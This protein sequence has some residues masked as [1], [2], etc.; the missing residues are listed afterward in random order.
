MPRPCVHKLPPSLQRIRSPVGLFGLVADDMRKGVLG[1]LAR[2][3]RLVAGPIAEGAA[4]AVNRRILNP[5]ATKQ[6]FQRHRRKR[7]VGALAGENEVGDLRLV[8]P[9]Q[10]RERGLAERNSM[11]ARSLRAL[12]RDGPDLGV[13]VDFFPTCAKNLAGPRR[14]KDGE[15]QRNGGDGLALAELGENPGRSW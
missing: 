11:L 12:R 8:D 14:R 5:H 15:F 3:M 6:H 10:D 2:E 4:E 1:E 9:P 13:N 7:S